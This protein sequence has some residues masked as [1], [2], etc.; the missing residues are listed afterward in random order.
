MKLPRIRQ[1]GL[2]VINLQTHNEA[3]ILKHLHN[4]F[5]K[6]N[7]PW[8]ELI[9][10]KHYRNGRL[11]SSTAP[12]GSFWWRDALKLIENYKGLAMVTVSSGQTCLLWDD[13]WNGQVRKQ[14]SL[15]LYSFA[16]NK[17][18][19]LRKAYDTADITDLFSLPMSVEAFNQFQNLQFE[20]SAL[21]HN[22]LNDSW[23]YIWG[24]TLFSSSKAYRT[25]TCH[26]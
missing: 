22:D 23:T 24:S 14:E 4:F 13:L 8:V 26:S 3:L 25:L 9:W 19:C 17:S 2:G 15:E 6:S 7:L 18:I 11:P 16:K 1:G 5:N 21:L 20:F 10:D 12:K